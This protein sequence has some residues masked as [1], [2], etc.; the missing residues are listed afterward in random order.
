MCS[1]K[2]SILFADFLFSVDRLNKKLIL[3]LRRMNRLKLKLRRAR[4]DTRMKMKVS[5]FLRDRYV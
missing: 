3:A 4:F 5:Y 2:C 1:N